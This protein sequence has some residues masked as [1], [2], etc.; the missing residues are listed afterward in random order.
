MK[1]EIDAFFPLPLLA[2][3]QPPPR[4]D[5]RGWMVISDLSMQIVLKAP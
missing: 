5:N 1:S 4:R 2:F 3:A